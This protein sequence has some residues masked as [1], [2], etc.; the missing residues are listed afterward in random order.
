MNKAESKKAD[1]AAS[2]GLEEVTKLVYKLL[3]EQDE[4]Y[5]QFVLE[6]ALHAVIHSLEHEAPSSLHFTHFILDA[7]T[8]SVFDT[9]RREMEEL[10]VL[11]SPD[12]SGMIH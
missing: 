6:G 5:R 8:S 12:D 9:L 2:N 11:S 1:K 4:K 10:D 3:E 7:V